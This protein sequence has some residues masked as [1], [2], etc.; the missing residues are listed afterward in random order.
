MFNI[1]QYTSNY[2]T[3]KE[4]RIML[5]KSRYISEV[6]ERGPDLLMCVG[7]GRIILLGEQCCTSWEFRLFCWQSVLS[8]VIAQSL[9]LFL[10]TVFV[11]IIFNMYTCLVS[12]KWHKMAWNRTTLSR[13][14]RQF[15]T[16]TIIHLWQVI[17]EILKKSFEWIFKAYYNLFFGRSKKVH[18]ANLKSIWWGFYFT[19]QDCTVKI[20]EWSEISCMTQKTTRTFS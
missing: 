12:L 3:T 11:G 7:T 6:Y 5:C 14:I 20:M 13:I 18:F 16:Q 1:Q 17:I 9:S 2:D 4:S 10:W 8:M 15:L 19:I